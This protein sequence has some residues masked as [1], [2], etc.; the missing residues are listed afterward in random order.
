MVVIAVLITL[1]RLLPWRQTAARRVALAL[2]VLAI[3]VA[4]APEDVPGLTIPGS[5]GAMHT[6]G[7]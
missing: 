7:G 3:A 2:A 1:E 6:M 4:V 5:S